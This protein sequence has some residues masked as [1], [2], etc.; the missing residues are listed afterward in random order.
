VQL[1]TAH[2]IRAMHRYCGVRIKCFQRYAGAGERI[3]Y[4]AQRPEKRTT[5]QKAL[6]NYLIA[7]CEKRRLIKFTIC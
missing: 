6:L 7:F 4:A 1:F 5:L 2:V 3:R